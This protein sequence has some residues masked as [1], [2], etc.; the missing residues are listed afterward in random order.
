MLELSA[1]ASAYIFFTS[2]STGVPK[3]VLGTHLGL[4]HFIEWQRSNFKI[5]CGDHTAQLTAL[6]F[7]LVL[8]DILFPLT[9]GACIHI[10]R[11]ETLLDARRMLKWI[12]DTGITAMHCCLH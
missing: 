2:G 6:S 3:G 9:S 10:P 1:D 7:D 4:A 5:G 11:R 8:R 12:V